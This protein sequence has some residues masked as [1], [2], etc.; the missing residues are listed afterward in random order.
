MLTIF[1]GKKLFIP[2]L[3]V[4]VLFL[5]LAFCQAGNFTKAL[6]MVMWPTAH[7]A[8]LLFIMA[9]SASSILR[10]R[11]GKLGETYGK[12]AMRNRRYIG[13]NFAVVHFTHAGLVLS[14][15]TVTDASRPPEVLAVG[16]LAYVFLALMVLTSNNGA[17]R[18]L[19]A[20]NWKRLHK[21]GS[22][23]LLALFFIT[24]FRQ[25]DAFTSLQ[26]SWVAIASAGVLLI[27][28]SAY[29]KGKKHL[30]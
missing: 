16:G 18:K 19:G 24:S 25:E 2:V 17:V 14:N 10:L 28:F 9:F 11:R 15:L 21:F 22:Y 13:L 23:Y 12:W 3:L 30:G 20:K 6:P 5:G 8:F 4:L 7:M 29:R 1:D 27:R 26:S